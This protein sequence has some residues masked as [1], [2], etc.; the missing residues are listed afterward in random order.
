M[1]PLFQG[2]HC[3]QQQ[4]DCPSDIAK[5]HTCTL[6][7]V[8]LLLHAGG[9][10]ASSGIGLC[11][12]CMGGSVISSSIITPVP[13]LRGTHEVNPAHGQYS[14]HHQPATSVQVGFLTL[15]LLL[16]WYCCCCFFPCSM[17]CAAHMALTL[18][19]RGDMLRLLS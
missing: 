18:Q 5:Q 7:P 11:S 10:A 15:L 3:D 8:L 9:D 1:A 17:I 19:V 4:H 14:T 6:Y 2:G 12:S 13:L 16:L